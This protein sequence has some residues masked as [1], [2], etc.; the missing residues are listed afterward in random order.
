MSDTDLSV[1]PK[2]LPG[3]WRN[4]WLHVTLAILCSAAGQL[5]MKM[6]ADAAVLWTAGGVE[7]WVSWLGVAALGSGW[8]WL[9]IVFYIL[10]FGSW[11][12]AL[13]FLPLG[14]AF[15]LTNVVYVLV[16]VA[17][18]LFLGEKLGSMRVIGIILIL[19]GIGILAQ[20]VTRIE[21]RL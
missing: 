1:I 19:V 7:T 11:L 10:S 17:S 4:P 13:R 6:G 21:D 3:L 12:Y 2:P 16:P 15:N 18:W 8:T 20:S 14:L 9:G 5:L